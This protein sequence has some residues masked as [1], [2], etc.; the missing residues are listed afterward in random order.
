MRNK[1]RGQKIE[2]MR[3]AITCGMQATNGA[4]YRLISQLTTKR[5]KHEWLSYPFVRLDFPTKDCIFDT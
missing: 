2:K 4:V 1:A 3:Q 5:L